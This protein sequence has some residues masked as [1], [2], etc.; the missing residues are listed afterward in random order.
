MSQNLARLQLLKRNLSTTLVSTESAEVRV[1]AL[2]QQ[3]TNLKLSRKLDQHSDRAGWFE[4]RDQPEL[5]TKLE[6]SADQKLFLGSATLKLRVMTSLREGPK[7]RSIDLF[8][9]SMTG[10]EYPSG[11]LFSALVLSFC[12]SLDGYNQIYTPAVIALVLPGSPEFQD[13]EAVIDSF[14]A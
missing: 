2:V 3:I 1:G 10:S 12:D 6:P 9:F 13:I 5:I 7:A 11:H 4:C 8:C 14:A